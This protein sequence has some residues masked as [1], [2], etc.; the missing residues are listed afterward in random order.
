LA[1][2]VSV[3]TWRLIVRVYSLE[4]ATTGGLFTGNRLSV[5]LN[6]PSAEITSSKLVRIAPYLLEEAGD[7]I[8][9]LS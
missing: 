9:L 6:T 8:L 1:I 4:N 3:L 2:I 7:D 5:F